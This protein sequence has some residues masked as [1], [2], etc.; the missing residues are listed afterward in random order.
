M[1]KFYF[2]Q[3]A[4]LA[5]FLFGFSGLYAQVSVTATAGTPGPTTYATLNAAFAAINAGTHQGSIQISITGNT[6]EPAVS[7]PLLKSATPSSYTDITIKPSGGDFV[8][9]SAAAPTASRGVIELNGADNVTID[10]DDVSTPGIRN[11]TFSVT[12]VSTTGIAAI[13][14]ASSSATDGATFN[15]VKNCI[16][17]GSRLLET[18]TTANYGIYSGTA[19]TASISASGQS[20]NNDN[21][22]I[23]N[24][25][26]SRCFFG[27]YAAGTT[28][29]YMDNLVIQGNTLGTSAATAD[30][31]VRAIYVQNTQ[32]LSTPGASVAVIDGNDIQA[33]T[34]NG[35]NT[36]SALEIANGNAGAI[37]KNNY[38]HDCLNPTSS[39]WGM[40]GIGITGSTNNSAIS[41]Y[42]NFIR[43]ISGYGTSSTGSP[44][45]GSGIAL[46]VG[47]LGM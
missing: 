28:A 29:N 13:R 47:V 43:D 20:D 38:I 2:R 3:I 6:T 35:G 21:L 37:V 16:I 18:S 11:L 10:G 23:Q 34:T 36:Y 27:I 45:A 19:G 8:I 33:G 7:V 42:N 12:Q 1:M 4:L 9:G 17:K 41:I 5:A 24:N 40:Y 14:F 32:A 39:V 31:V 46:T 44:Y 26:I 30:R 25:L 22:T 15:T